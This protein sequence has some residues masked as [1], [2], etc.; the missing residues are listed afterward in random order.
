[1]AHCDVRLK[2][3]FAL[4]ASASLKHD[5]RE[6]SFSVLRKAVYTQRRKERGIRLKPRSGHGLNYVHV[7]FSVFS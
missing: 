3:A 7:L 2:M 5:L 1:M 4:T 6:G